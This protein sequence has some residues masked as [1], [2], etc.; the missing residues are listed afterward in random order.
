MQNLLSSSFL[1]KNL[2][3]K[4][5]RTI[6]LPIALH[7]FETWSL[8]QR[9]ERR[10]RVLEN[11]ALRIFG[12]TK[13]NVTGECKK[14]HT[15]E[16]TDLY[17][18]PNIIRVIKS[19]RM[20]RV[21]HVARMSERCIQG[22]GGKMRERDHLEDPDVDGRIILKWIFRKWYGGMDWTDLFQN[23]DRWK[24]LVNAVMNLRIP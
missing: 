24:E 14:V 5:Y 12:P 8:T 22:F 11:R 17:S 6:I 18:S 4:I 10:P 21:G 13:D 23:R 16:L 15:E 3:I 9:K 7:G 20:R 19:R 2:K 1:S